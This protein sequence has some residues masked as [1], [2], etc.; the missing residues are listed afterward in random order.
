MVD[1]KGSERERDKT[2]HQDQCCYNTTRDPDEG[3]EAAL[4]VAQ[5]GKEDLLKH[6]GST[7]GDGKR[8]AEHA[9][10]GKPEH[11]LRRLE[12]A[13]PV[14]EGGGADH[15]HV[16]GKAR[17][18]VGGAGVEV[19]RAQNQGQNEEET[20]AR[21]QGQADSAPHEGLAEGAGGSQKVA[22]EVE[23]GDLGRVRQQAAEVGADG[24]N[25]NVQPAADGIVGRV[26]PGLQAIAMAEVVGGLPVVERLIAVLDGREE[27]GDGVG[28]QEDV[29]G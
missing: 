23:L 2:Y 11:A 22:E 24:V 10:D 6:K 7:Q 5:H 20:D 29:E 1:E 12:P 25:G 21:V 8:P 14:H 17:R 15:D 4:V 3:L 16:H 28:G 19:A 9:A 18:E 13:T 26:L 27:G